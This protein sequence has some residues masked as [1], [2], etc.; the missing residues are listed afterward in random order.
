MEKHLENKN[1]DIHKHVLELS[2]DREKE[3]QQIKN[4]QQWKSGGRPRSVESAFGG[5]KRER[6]NQITNTSI[7]LQIHENNSDSENEKTNVFSMKI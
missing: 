2:K 4:H 7:N 6:Q 1:I 3:G 5:L